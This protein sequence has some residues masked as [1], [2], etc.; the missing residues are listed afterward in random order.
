VDEYLGDFL[1]DTFQPFHFF[2][3]EEVDYVVPPYGPREIYTAGAYT[4]P[5][6]SST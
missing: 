1:F 3:N 2:Q 5:L 6:L 4:R